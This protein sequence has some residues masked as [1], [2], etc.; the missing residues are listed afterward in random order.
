MSN[1]DS[2]HNTGDKV[3]R[4]FVTRSDETRFCNNWI[5]FF[6][7]GDLN[8]RDFSPQGVDLHQYFKSI[9]E[10]GINEKGPVFF[11]ETLNSHILSFHFFPIESIKDNLNAISEQVNSTNMSGEKPSIEYIL[12]IIF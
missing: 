1:L 4:I 10:Q 3:Q 8:L 7:K 11:T 12:I 5:S 6:Q 9:F 2:N